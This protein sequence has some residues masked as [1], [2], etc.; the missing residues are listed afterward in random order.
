MIIIFFFFERYYKL[1]SNGIISKSND[2]LNLND[3]S[4][5]FEFRGYDSMNKNVIITE[6]T[7]PEPG[8]LAASRIIVSCSIILFNELDKITVK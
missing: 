4:F 2:K 6:V 8:Y 1:F 7:G 5:R 3:A